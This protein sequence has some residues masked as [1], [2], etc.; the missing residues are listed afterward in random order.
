MTGAAAQPRFQPVII[1][2]S[3]TSM[4][5][6]SPRLHGHRAISVHPA[7]ELLLASV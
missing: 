7:V 3:R 2:D 6:L 1:S 5:S 4:S